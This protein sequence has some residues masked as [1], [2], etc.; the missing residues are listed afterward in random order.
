MDFF[1]WDFI[2]SNLCVKITKMSV[3]E[4][5]WEKMQLH[6]LQVEFRG[7]INQLF[8]FKKYVAKNEST[9]VLHLYQTAIC[10]QVL[11]LNFIKDQNSTSFGVWNLNAQQA[12][13]MEVCTLHS[14]PATFTITLEQREPGMLWEIF[15][16]T[17]C[18]SVYT[19]GLQAFD[20]KKSVTNT[21][22]NSK[23]HMWLNGKWYGEDTSCPSV[24]CSYITPQQPHIC[25]SYGETVPMC[26]ESLV[27][28]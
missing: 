27:C 9:S 22:R 25:S 14:M 3:L 12:S 20:F 18:F 5:N 21:K 7:S 2:G 19:K 10:N 4:C 11:Q 13:H 16:F 17:K 28:L 8:F 26:L 6:C 23:K 1:F 24:S 15:K